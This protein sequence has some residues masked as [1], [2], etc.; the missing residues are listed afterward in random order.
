MRENIKRISRALRRFSKP[1]TSFDLLRVEPVGSKMG[2]ERGTPVD[3]KYIESFLQ[4][5]C[6][7]IRGRTMEIGDPKYVR[8][9][10]GD[11]VTNTEVLHVSKENSK[12]TL[13]GDLSRPEGLPENWLDCFVCT[14]TLNFIY[15]FKAAVRGIH[16]LLKPGGKALVT[17][18]GISQISRYDMDRW[19]DFWRFTPLSAKLTF[20]EV[21]K[22]EVEVN[23]HGNV[24]A[25]CAFLQGLCVEDLPDA[26]L[27]EHN[28]PDFPMIVT[29]VAEKAA[30][31]LA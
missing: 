19:G 8:M 12:A 23:G 26:T 31:P 30:N 14:Q 20:E 10:G 27:L 7:S 16:R 28:D 11:R 1:V 15:D 22:G 4:H 6:M 21:F 25:A 29:V 24:L 18:A 17:L 5:N 3:R 2:L 9:F 13:I